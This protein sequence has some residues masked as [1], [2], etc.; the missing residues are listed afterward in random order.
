M[1][2][3]LFD[4]DHTLL[5]LDSDHAWGEF[6]TQLGWH[7][8]ASFRAINDRFYDQ[9]KMGVLNLAEYIAFTTEGIRR[10]GQDAA[11]AAHQRFMHEIIRPAIRPQ[12]LALLQKHRDAGDTLVL[13]TATNEF[14]TRP[15]AQ[16]LGFEHLLA[17]ELQ[18]GADGW[19]NGQIQ[20]V[21]SFREGKVT[22]MQA[23]LA[24]RGCSLDAIE[25]SC[26]Y[27]DSINDL[28]LLEQVQ[29][30]VATNPDKSLLSIARERQWQVLQ[31]FA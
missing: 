22:R 13:I 16:E 9:Y 10:V 7:E 21:P 8:A 5:P 2:L 4:L 17:V 27:S 20:G 1:K 26:F 31:L 25:R 12:A 15:I 19:Y 14:V 30:P 23:W 29:S 28:P 6:T 3:A 24:E 18:K 11:Q